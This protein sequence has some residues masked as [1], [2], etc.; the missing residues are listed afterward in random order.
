[1]LLIV[2]LLPYQC[3]FPS[4]I[5]CLLSK[6]TSVALGS[7]LCLRLNSLDPGRCGSNIGL[8]IFKIIPHSKVHGAN[9]G[10]IWGRQDPG[11]THVGPMNFA[12]SDNKDRC[13]NHF[14]WNCPQGNAT[15]S[16][17]VMAW[18]HQAVVCY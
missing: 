15:R 6:V 16:V 7:L 14:L 18:L 13:L 10:P 1:M 9:M 3:S 8:L 17:Q 5:N 12:I 4:T 11:G 2:F